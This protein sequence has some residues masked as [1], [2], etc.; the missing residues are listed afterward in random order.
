VVTECQILAMQFVFIRPLTSILA[1]VY[2]TVY[3]TSSHRGGV[4]G[5]DDNEGNLSGSAVAAYFA[6]PLFV[7]AMITNVSVFLAFTGLLKFYHA[8]RD[9]L[10]WCQP[11]SKFMTIKGIVFLTFW[12]GLLISIVVSA[13]NHSG[14]SSDGN[15]KTIQH[16]PS[17]NASSAVPGSSGGLYS[18][19]TSPGSTTSSY[20]NGTDRYLM[21][22]QQSS[23]SSSDYSSYAAFDEAAQIQNFLI[24]LEMLFFSIAHYCVFPAEEWEPGYRPRALARPGIGLKDFVSDMSYII[25]SRRNRTNQSTKGC[26]VVPSFEEFEDDNGDRGGA[27]DDDVENRRRGDAA[28]KVHF[29]E[30]ESSSSSDTAGFPDALDPEGDVLRRSRSRRSLDEEKSKGD[31]LMLTNEIPAA[32]SIGITTAASSTVVNSTLSAVHPIL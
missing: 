2:N 10:R 19:W 3:E 23:S 1:F 13:L 20:H 15:V 27:G 16:H 7:L 14:R 31:S 22:A 24:C 6:S 26:V 21:G 12:Q 9:D 28:E 32:A 29:D 17:S 11:F 18:S 8:V 30:D 25:K 5:E 4:G